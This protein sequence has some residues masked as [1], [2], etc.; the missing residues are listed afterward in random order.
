MIVRENRA[1]VSHR[2]CELH[3]NLTA[4]MGTQPWNQQQLHASCVLTSET[5]VKRLDKNESNRVAQ[6]DL[7]RF[8]FPNCQRKPYIFVGS[9]NHYVCQ[10]QPH[11][12]RSY[13][14]ATTRIKYKHHHH[15]ALHT[16][17]LLSSFE[18]DSI[19]LFIVNIISRIYW[20]NSI[21]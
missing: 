1:N 2:A 18:F 21:W 9:A 16:P 5:I 10:F 7:S 14:N 17:Y 13:K 20:T 15:F 11:I 8:C 3:I 4:V 6:S 19:F 12:Q